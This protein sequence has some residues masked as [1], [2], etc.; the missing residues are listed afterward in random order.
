MF[1]L[2]LVDHLRLTFGH[3]I[4]TH[5]AHT[6]LALRYSRWNRWTQALEALLL[7]AA[8][9]SSIVMLTTGEWFYA[10]GAA[11]ASGLAVCAVVLR[12]VADFEGR[13][14]A[15]R[16]CSAQLWHAR[17]QYRA[18]LA[19]L[20]DGHITIDHARERRDA[21][22]ATLQAVYEKAPS[23]DRSALD[24]ARH[25]MPAE[26][27]AALADPEIDRFLPESLQKTGKSAA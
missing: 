10:L 3:V 16:A 11:I 21:L 9:V 4:Y 17:E 13:V 14:S 25:A 12:L 24:A 23:A 1:G 8:L 6:R 19:D 2:T 20:K 22:M 5:R 27:E 7:L 15:H 18:L 26:H